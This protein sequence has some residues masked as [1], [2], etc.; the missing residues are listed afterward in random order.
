MFWRAAVSQTGILLKRKEAVITLYI[1]LGMVLFNFIK[2]VLAFQGS[3]ILSMYHPMKLL[4]LSYDITNYNASGTL[5]F[6][7]LYPIL[8]VCPAGFALSRE[9]QLGVDVYMSGRLGVRTYRLS[10]MVAAFLTTMLVFT[11]PF[12]LEFILNC[13]S[14]PLSAQG[15]LLNWNYYDPAYIQCIRNYF[16][17]D[18]Y[19]NNPFLY[20]IAGILFFGIVSGLL[21]MFVVSFSSLIR[22]KYNIFLFFPVIVLLNSTFMFQKE[23]APSSLWYDYLL[24]FSEMK[25]N[26]LVFAIGVLFVVLFSFIAGYFGSRKDC[27]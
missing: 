7:Q 13:L 2:N 6:I 5:F 17:T 14:F 24:L 1:L 10:K 8:V 20:T 12:L 27:L 4:F 22:I 15:D 26:M 21:G 16:M 18:F 19:I 23:G 25:K 9:Y 3:D 11:I